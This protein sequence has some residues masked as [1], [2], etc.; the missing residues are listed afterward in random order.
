MIPAVYE[1]LIAADRL[2]VSLRPVADGGLAF[3]R[4]PVGR[5]GDNLLKAMIANRAEILAALAGPMTACNWR[6]CTCGAEVRSDQER[7]PQPWCRRPM[8]PMG[9]TP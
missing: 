9:D 7:C 1:V 2:G 5:E 4:L 6:P 8:R 3:D